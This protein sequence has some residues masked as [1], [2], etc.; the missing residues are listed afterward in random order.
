MDI[1]MTELKEKIKGLQADLRQLR[2]DANR[3]FNETAVTRKKILMWTYP[4]NGLH[5]G[6]DL[7]NLWDRMAAAQSLGFT[8]TLEAT[9]EGIEVY[10][11]QKISTS[12]PT[13]FWV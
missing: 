10:Y 11:H 1:Q 9:D 7:Q 3:F 8:V 13:S 5:K 12:R 2:Q 6:W 4:K